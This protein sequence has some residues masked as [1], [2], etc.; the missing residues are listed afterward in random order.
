VAYRFAEK[1]EVKNQCA[2]VDLVFCVSSESSALPVAKPNSARVAILVVT[3]VFAML[4]QQ[5]VHVLV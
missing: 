3:C 5:F 1:I 4:T 2:F